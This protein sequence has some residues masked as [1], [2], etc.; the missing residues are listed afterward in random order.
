VKKVQKQ[1]RPI[2][3]GIKVGCFFTPKWNIDFLLGGIHI[4][5]KTQKI[6]FFVVFF[7]EKN[8]EGENCQQRKALTSSPIR[9]AQF[10]EKSFFK[11]TKN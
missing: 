1:E 6:N 3:T 7:C 9:I 10:H 2:D 8:D 5:K 4:G 11:S